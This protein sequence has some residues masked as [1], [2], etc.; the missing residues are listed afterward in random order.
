MIFI[1]HDEKIIET[2]KCRLSGKE[3]IVT[4]KDVELLD[5][6]SP[7]FDNK[8]YSLPSPTLSP[9]ERQKRRLTFRNERKM[10]KSKCSKTGREIIS[11]YSPDK[12][13]IVYDQKVWW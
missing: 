10:Y 9:E 11:L 12:N 8:K 7:I 13:Y 4:D 5:K 2:R 6:I 1:P 3:F